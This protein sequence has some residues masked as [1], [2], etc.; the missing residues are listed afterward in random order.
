M[1]ASIIAA[2]SASQMWT[3]ENGSDQPDSM[4]RKI[5]EAKGGRSDLDREGQDLRE[6]RA[7]AAAVQLVVDRPCVQSNTQGIRH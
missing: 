7:L 4:H 1:H 2:G 3:A 6:E 5:I